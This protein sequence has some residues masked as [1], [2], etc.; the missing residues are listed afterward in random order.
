MI[1]LERILEVEDYLQGYEVFKNGISDKTCHPDS[2]MTCVDFECLDRAI[3]DSEF[4]FETIE[5]AID[6]WTN[7]PNSQP[8]LRIV[9]T[10]WKC[11][12]EQKT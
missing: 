2:Y 6:Y 4:D 11:K 9:S 7:S 5:G 8:P 1:E 12:L 10:M 3:S